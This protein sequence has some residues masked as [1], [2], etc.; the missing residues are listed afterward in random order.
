M[1]FAEFFTQNARE[2]VPLAWKKGLLFLFDFRGPF[3]FVEA[4]SA[5]LHAALRR[6]SLAALELLRD[7]FIFVAAQTEMHENG[8]ADLSISIAG[9]GGRADDAQLEAVLQRLEL[10]ER[11]RV[12]ADAAQEGARVALGSCPITGATLSFAANRSDGLLFAFDLSAPARLIEDGTAP[13]NADGERAWLVSDT[14]GVY[15]SLVRRLQ[16]LGWATSTFTS[17]QRAADQLASMTPGM[18]RPSL[19]IGAQSRHIGPDQLG[20]LRPLLPPRTL[21]VLAAALDSQLR[22]VPGV[23][24]RHW[25]FSPAE[26]QEFTRRLRGGRPVY[27]GETVPAPM[28]FTDRPRALVVDD[29]AVNLLVASGLLQMAGFEVETATGGTE[30][31]ARC[32]DRVPQLVLMDV[33]MPGMSGLEAAQALAEDWPDNGKPFP[34]I[35]FVTAYDQYALQAF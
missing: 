12:G 1:D 18:A 29:N 20:A 13:P 19:V 11:P 32:R 27:S 24:L 4:D 14:P 28:S 31:V 9:T 10:R 15:Q 30:A 7:G 23:E 17:V 25:P 2:L 35:V 16:R 26:L 5:P 22:P 21:L 33:H 3:V 8:T 34:L 6:V